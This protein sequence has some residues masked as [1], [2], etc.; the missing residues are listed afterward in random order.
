M[1]YLL[2]LGMGSSLTQARQAA[3]IA[4]QNAIK[5]A[6]D[7]A[8]AAAKAAENAVARAAAAADD[9]AKA[10]AK[11][12][13]NMA[14][15][16]TKAA[17][18]R[19]QDIADDA[20]KAA[21]NA[22]KLSAKAADDAAKAAA[23][24]ADDA[25]EA[26]LKNNSKILAWMAKN[27]KT[28]FGVAAAAVFGAVVYAEARKMFDKNNGAELTISKIAVVDKDKPTNLQIMFDP[29]IKILKGDTVSF[30]NDTK[31]FPSSVTEKD[32]DINSI[33][34]NSE[35][36]ITIPVLETKTLG[37]LLVNDK[38]LIILRMTIID[39]NSPDTLQII[40]D[41][42]TTITRTNVIK[43]KDP[44]DIE[45]SVRIKEIVSDTEIKV[46]ISTLENP[47]PLGVLILETSMEACLNQASSNTTKSV[48]D[49]PVT[50]ALG[51][52]GSGVASGLGNVFGGLFSSLFKMFGPA[53]MWILIAIGLVLCIPIIKLIFFRK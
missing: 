20:A 9:A 7:A 52:V 49:N 12:A 43:Y 45:H 22:T 51:A 36:N 47:A 46:T 25:A 24:A 44:S 14:D 48:F 10:A 32:I 53:T 8:K 30:R 16:A 38:Q 6:D 42:K 13:D 1:S 37:S 31:I 26:S 21:A 2:R 41:Q 27:P 15:D 28:T 29:S 34:S 40:F 5:A 35:I 19:A 39:K 11:A 3:K 33:A 17:A 50:N 23:K 18:K 4:S